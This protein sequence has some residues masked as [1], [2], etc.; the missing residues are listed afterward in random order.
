M[1][2]Y[3]LSQYI[4]KSAVE[5]K[6]CLEALQKAQIIDHSDEK[7]GIKD[8]R[9]IELCVNGVPPLSAKLIDNVTKDE[10]LPQEGRDR[11]ANLMIAAIS[12]MGTEENLK[13]DKAV[14]THPV[15]RKGGYLESCL[16]IVC[17]CEAIEHQASRSS[18]GARSFRRKTS[19]LKSKQ[20]ASE[21]F[22]ALFL[23]EDEV[24]VQEPHE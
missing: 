10:S 13:E 18:E 6:N 3:G 8:E 16:E 24:K 22:G 12:I 2:D 5:L 23:N 21:M 17:K 15:W 19:Q 4:D 20:S 9:M 14:K 1:I 11:L 7:Y